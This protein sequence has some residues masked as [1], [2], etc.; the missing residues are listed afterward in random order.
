MSR[1]NWYEALKCLIYNWSF[2][3]HVKKH[4]S[5]GDALV[6]AKVPASDLTVDAPLTSLPVPLT[7]ARNGV[8]S[9]SEK[10]TASRLPNDGV[11]LSSSK[12]NGDTETIMNSGLSKDPERIRH[13][14]AATKAQAAF[15]GYLVITS[16]CTC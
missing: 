4:A 16:F 9:D 12:E 14:Q 1:G 5:K 11:I 8:V 2:D 10:G 3:S 6:C 15:R 7:T 13:E